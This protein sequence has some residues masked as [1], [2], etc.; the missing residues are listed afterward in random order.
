MCAGVKGRFVRVFIFLL[1]GITM[2]D[3]AQERERVHP[4]NVWDKA[5][6]YLPT[7]NQHTIWQHSGHVFVFKGCDKK[8]K[9]NNSINRHKKLYGCEPHHRKSFYTFSMWGKG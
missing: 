9:T 1:D 8:C 5:F 6:K 7:P 2:E 4:C 3:K